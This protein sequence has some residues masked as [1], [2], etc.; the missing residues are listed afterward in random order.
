MS[1]WM[2]PQSWNRRTLPLILMSLE[3][4]LNH[5]G[6]THIGRK[7]ARAGLSDEFNG[8]ALNPHKELPSSKIEFD[9]AVGADSLAKS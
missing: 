8:T 7:K 9:L 6:L 3:Q 4:A 2:S 1:I 5:M